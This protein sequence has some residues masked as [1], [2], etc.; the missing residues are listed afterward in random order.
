MTTFYFDTSALV[1][2]YVREAGTPWVVTTIDAP[3]NTT[4][5]ASITLVE[6]ISG[7]ARKMRSG[8]ITTIEFAQ[9]VQLLRTD[10]SQRR[11]QLQPV[12]NRV[13][14]EATDLL[15]T[16]AAAGQVLR[17]YDAVQLASGVSANHALLAAGQP[18][19]QFVTADRR[20]ATIAQ[21]AGLI[22]IDPEAQP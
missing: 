6:A 9:F 11:Y 15:V 22:V 10:F 16:H 3:T 20:L 2:Y 8:Q 21:V 17:G 5:T 1:K 14:Q 13:I 19:L 18:A 4:V 12:I 7:F